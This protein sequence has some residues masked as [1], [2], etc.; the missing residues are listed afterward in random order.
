[1]LINNDGRKF[2]RKDIVLA[3][4]TAVP[5]NISQ[6]KIYDMDADGRDDIVYIAANG[7]LAILYGTETSGIFTRNILDTTLGISLSPEP[8]QIG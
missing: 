3:D 5:Q 6:F 2:A 8:L 4:D 1:M 7:E